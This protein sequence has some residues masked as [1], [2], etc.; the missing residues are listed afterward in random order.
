MKRKDSFY[1]A[2][3]STC[4]VTKYTPEKISKVAPIFTKFK[5]SLPTIN[6]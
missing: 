4:F 3:F 2:E 6:A 1:L 5:E